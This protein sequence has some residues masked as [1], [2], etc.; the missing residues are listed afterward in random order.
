MSVS[1]L[2]LHV[3]EIC[4]S[5]LYL[6]S[7]CVLCLYFLPLELRW[8]TSYICIPRQWGR[9]KKAERAGCLSGNGREPSY[10]QLFPPGLLS[11]TL[12]L[13]LSDVTCCFTFFKFVLRFS[14]E[15]VSLLYTHTHTHTHTYT[16]A[17]VLSHISCVGFCA[18]TWTAALQTP[19]S[20]GFSRQEYWSGLPCPPPGDPP[21]PGIEPA[22]L[23][24]HPLAGECFTT[25]ATTYMY[26]HMCICLY[27]CIWFIIRQF[28]WLWR[29]PSVRWRP[30]KPG[31]YREM[32]TG[33][34]FSSPALK[35]GEL[36]AWRA[37]E[38]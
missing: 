25:S 19:L 13:A 35:T 34:V 7:L 28:L 20:M 24:S 12:E 2:Y 23:K 37:G 27:V 32:G 31:V 8:T 9:I 5:I 1:V 10:P 21:I 36:G 11:T 33:G 18:T 30:R 3:I 17:C 14:R 6:Y 29:L 4:I 15:A 38:D 16:Y 26:I 22:S